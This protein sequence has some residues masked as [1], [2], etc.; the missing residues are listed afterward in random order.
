[1]VKACIKKHTKPIDTALKSAIIKLLQKKEDLIMAGRQKLTLSE[2]LAKI[3]NEI[4]EVE[5]QLDSLKSQRKELLSQKE[6]EE[7]KELYKIIRNS[8]KSMSEVKELI[9]K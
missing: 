5:N 8:G 4:R 9:M 7:L 3:E 6:Q 1:M 2:K